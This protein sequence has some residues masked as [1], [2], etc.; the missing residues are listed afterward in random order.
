MSL[1]MRFCLSVFWLIG[2]A[3]LFN[4]TPAFAAAIPE[5]EP[6]NNAQE[7]QLL[8]TIG[9]DNPVTAAIN[10]PGE[11]DWYKFEVVTGRTYVV[12]VYNLDV[13]L[14]RAGGGNCERFANHIGLGLMIH[15]SSVTELRRQC[16]PFAGGNVQNSLVFKATAT[17]T[18]YLTVVP[19]SSAANVSGNYAL[20]IL[21]R[22][23]E[24]GAAWDNNSAEPNNRNEIALEVTQLTDDV[25]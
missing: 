8:S 20:R 13:G 3:W 7:A 23:D 21:P 1:S 24:P 22:H 11:Q 2:F 15:D 16:A 4:P 10:T 25:N 18:F 17:G 12:E 9:L 19:H 14:G 5:Q 6:N